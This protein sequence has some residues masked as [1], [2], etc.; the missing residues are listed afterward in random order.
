MSGTVAGPTV[1]GSPVAGPTASEAGAA[2]LPPQEQPWDLLV[3]GGGTAGLVGAQTAARFGARVLLVERARTGGDCLWT[4]CVP[5]KSLLAA[6]HLAAAARDGGRLGV[7]AAVDVGF[8]EVVEHVRAAIRTIEPVDSPAAIEESGAVVVRG[9]ATFTG[10]GSADVDGR[11]VAFRQALVATGSG[12]ALPPI[13]GLDRAGALTSETV[14]DLRE[15]PERLVVLGGGTIGCEL[16][17][18]FARLGAQVSVVHSHEQVLPREDPDAAALVRAAL[19]GDGVDVLTGSRAAAVE[20]DPGGPGGT[21]VLA[22][23]R[24]VGYDRLLVALGRTPRTR[25]L[26]LDAAGVELDGHGCVR[27]DAHLRTTNPRIWAAG[28]VTGP[29]QFTHLAGV[30]A[31]LAASNAVLGLRRSVD[32]VVPRVTFTSPEVAAVGVRSGPRLPAGLRTET[33]QHHHVDRAVTEGETAG[34][35]RLVL[36][37]RSRIVGATIVGPRAGESLAE[38]ALAIRQ[39]LRTRDVAG[40]THAYPTY[41]DGVWSAAI[42][43]VRRSLASPAVAGVVGGL[44]RLRRGWL[45]LRGRAGRTPGQ[46]RSAR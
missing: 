37:S 46:A 44:V 14:W 8:P 23:G 42:A 39:G 9:T 28:D 10:P 31:A 5:S 24:R 33:V 20:P 19:E 30:R 32:P 16:G 29:P 4:G 11:H 45:D 27:V 2:P 6:A 40:T 43:D 7:L 26:G 12:P 3:V 18:A 34:F 13:P 36:D 21:V 25:G 41:G 15:L 35:T 1:S 17:Q 22:D 38:V